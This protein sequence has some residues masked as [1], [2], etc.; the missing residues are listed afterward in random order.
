MI[1]RI[2]A[3]DMKSKNIT[4]QQ[5]TM[6][7]TSA[8][9]AKRQGEYV[10]KQP[11]TPSNANIATH[12]KSTNPIVYS[13]FEVVGPHGVSYS[14]VVVNSLAYL[15]TRVSYEECTRNR[16]SSPRLNLAPLLW[17]F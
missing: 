1:R 10:S 8:A 9:A 3:R 4:T 14:C 15:K 7:E 5:T 12:P 11:Q 13:Y 6:L 16:P 17:R 2:K